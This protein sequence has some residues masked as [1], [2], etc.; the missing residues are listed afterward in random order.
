MNKHTKLLASFAA[1]AITLS[2]CARDLSSD[3]YTSDSTLSLTLEGTIVSSRAVKINNSDKLGDNATGTLAGGALGGVLGNNIGK[4]NGQTAAAVGGVIAG[5]IIGS[6]VENNL[7]K[8]EGIEYIIKVDGSKIKDTYY[9]GSTMMNAA[10][11]SAR[12]TG[13]LTVVQGKDNVLGAG[14][15]VFVIVSPKRTR[16]IPA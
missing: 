9:E 14:Q 1:I 4:G 11:S 5:A 3:L 6:M 12:A 8:S 2:S 13:M 15:K 16:V 10:I 7:S